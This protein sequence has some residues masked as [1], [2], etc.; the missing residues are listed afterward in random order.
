MPSTDPKDD[1]A[2]SAGA[3][4]HADAAGETA[5]EHPGE[6][7]GADE[8]ELVGEPEYT[9]AARA[10]AGGTGPE[11]GTGPDSGTGPGRGERSGSRV[12]GWVQW[13]AC[14]L[15]LVLSGVLAIAAVVARYADGTLLNTDRYV[16]MVSPLAQDESVR[17]K[18][19]D[20]VTDQVMERIDVETMT[21]SVLD[22]VAA[23]IDPEERPILSG[24]ATQRSDAAAA[25]LAPVIYGQ[26]ESLV[27]KIVTRVVDS[28]AFVAVWNNANRAGHRAVVYVVTGEGDVVEVSRDGVVHLSLGPVVDDV[29]AELQ[30]RGFSFAESIPAVDPQIAVGEFPQLSAVQNGVAWLARAAAWLPW[31]VVALGALAVWIAP[32]RRRGTALVG[33]TWAAAGLLLVGA[34]AFGR[35]KYLAALPPSVAD[36]AT[37][38]VF[39]R[40]TGPLRSQ[41]VWLTVIGVVLVV[42]VVVWSVWSGGRTPDDGPAPDSADELVDRPA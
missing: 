39:D 15:V 38:V 28:D 31:V 24:Q 10:R 12:P 11:A 4:E 9:A 36:D 32:A 17:G 41:G 13:T 22:G 33:G 1:A 16:A 35:G 7:S 18:V 29:R 26:V 37:G 14:G 20:V 27:R 6:P 23:S 5:T 21:A 30:D 2:G 3:A 25:A 34:I 42:A 8:Q 19:V 40:I